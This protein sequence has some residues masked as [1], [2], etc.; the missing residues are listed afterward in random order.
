MGRI[1][2]LTPS[3]YIW[4]TTRKEVTDPYMLSRVQSLHIPPAYTDVVIYTREEDKI[5]AYGFDAKGRKQTLYAKW[6]VE[7]QSAIK[8]DRVM[9]LKQTMQKIT[10]DVNKTLKDAIAKID[11]AYTAKEIKK[12]HICLVIKLTML[13]NFRIGNHSEKAYG[14]TTIQWRHVQFDKNTVAFS[15]VGKKGVLNEAVCK[16]QKV[17][18]LLKYMSD[19][20]N[21]KDAVFGISSSQVNTYLKSFDEDISSKDIRTWQANALFMKYF[22]K[23]A[24]TSSTCSLKKRQHEALKHVARALH[25]TPAVCKKSYIYPEFLMST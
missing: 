20:A 6:F 19:G 23:S 24:N 8:F 11:I 3:K 25:N 13:C 1:L 16:D 2:R 15:F 9:R 21:P 4:E 12:V 17:M 18:K 10:H 7:Q 5:Q 22:M 14:L